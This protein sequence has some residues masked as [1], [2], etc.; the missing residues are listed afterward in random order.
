MNI[1]QL[2]RLV[3]ETVREEQSRRPR[4]QRRARAQRNKLS[5]SLGYAKLLIEEAEESSKGPSGSFND[6]VQQATKLGDVDV[7]TAKGLLQLKNGDPNDVIKIG[8]LDAPC[9]SLKPSQSSM[10]LGKA[11]HFA[12]GMLNGTM[13]GSGGPGGELGA[14]TCGGY[15][16]DGHHRWIATC[17]VKPEANV[18]GYDMQGIKPED[19]V[20]VLNVA[21]AAVMGHNIGKEGS[22]SFSVFHEVDQV[23]AKLKEKNEDAGGVP[24]AKGKGKAAQVCAKWAE[25]EGQSLEGDEALKWAAQK[26]VENCGK[27][28]GVKDGA[29]LIS[30]NVR[31]DMP[32]ADDPE[33][34]SK[35]G[36]DIEAGFEKK[37]VATKKL[38]N[39]FEKGELDI[40]EAVEIKRW[41][42]LAGLLKD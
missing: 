14:F 21:T 24:N 25:S 42:K 8:K 17:M 10:N 4:T 29:V 26:M 12:L 38:I 2:R 23:L 9:K 30:T 36:G 28:P 33:Y 16:L 11:V 1:R 6:V 40:R 41:N 13:Y 20:R 18:Q 7:E 15:L 27:C 22:G 3:M 19:A 32:V 39:T 37:G 5:E 31:A 35:K 34:A